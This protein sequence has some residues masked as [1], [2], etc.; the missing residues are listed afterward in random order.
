MTKLDIDDIRFLNQ[1]QDPFSD[2]ET[3][4]PRL[5][6]MPEKRFTVHDDGGLLKIKARREVWVGKSNIAFM[7]PMTE[8]RAKVLGEKAEAK[9][10]AAN[11]P[12]GAGLGSA[13]PPPAP[14]Q[15]TGKAVRP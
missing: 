9:A 8:E 2:G 7:M 14:P 5:R 13:P 11:M 1:I 6:Q 3:L 4:I 15:N 10:P 12:A